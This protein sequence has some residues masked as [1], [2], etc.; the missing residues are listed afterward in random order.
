M[1]QRCTNKNLP[2]YESWG[3]RGITVCERW[4][5]SFEHFVADMGPRPMG[6]SID[7]IDNDG[8][9]E[10]DNCRWATDVEQANNRR[11]RRWHK[12]PLGLPTPPNV[13]SDKVA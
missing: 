2:D 9:Y 4:R 7:R 6:M 5:H 3:G 1:N 12:R 8:N 10:P 11:A 13:E